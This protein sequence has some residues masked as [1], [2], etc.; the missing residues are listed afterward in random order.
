MY[1]L[2]K[3]WGVVVMI[4]FPR[5]YFGERL[6][7]SIMDEDEEKNDRIEIKFKIN[8]SPASA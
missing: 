5:K 3:D 6:R 1:V 4:Y 8:S 2:G 7:I